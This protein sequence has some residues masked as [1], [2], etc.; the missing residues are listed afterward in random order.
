MSDLLIILSNQCQTPNSHMEVWTRPQANLILPVFKENQLSSAPKSKT[1]KM[2]AAS[3]LNATSL[4]P[5][6]LKPQSQN[7]KRVFLNNQSINRV[8]RNLLLKGKCN[9]RSVVP[10]RRKKTQIRQ[11]FHWLA[12]LNAPLFCLATKLR[13]ENSK[14]SRSYTLKLLTNSRKWA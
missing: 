4:K 6:K 2:T 11:K 10:S 9:N 5:T 3:K 14:A 13:T 1:S 7:S 12:N 8:N